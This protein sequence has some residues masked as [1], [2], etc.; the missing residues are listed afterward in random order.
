MWTISRC[1]SDTNKLTAL[2]P[3]TAVISLNVLGP[4]G[5]NAGAHAWRGRKR[6]RRAGSVGRK[7]RPSSLELCP[8]IQL[9]QAGAEG[10]KS[11]SPAS[12]VYLDPHER[13]QATRPS[14]PC[15]DPSEPGLTGWSIV[16]R[17]S[18]SPPHLSRSLQSPSQSP[19]GELCIRVGAG[20]PT[21]TYLHCCP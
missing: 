3:P 13:S 8:W 21:P 11:A 6:P 10:P 15:A 2:R 17:S 4:C 7:L 14:T 9:S 12:S 19:L 18:L 20:D 1:W 16:N 5:L